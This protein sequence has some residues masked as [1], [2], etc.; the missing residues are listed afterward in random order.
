MRTFRISVEG[1]QVVIEHGGFLLAFEPRIAVGGRL[2]KPLSLRKTENGIL[3]EYEW[4][5]GFIR[6]TEWGSNTLVVEVEAE[7]LS[8]DGI[9]AE[10][11]SRLQGFEDLLLFHYTYDPDKYFGEAEEPYPYPQLREAG[12]VEISAW[13]FPIHRKDYK[14]LPKNLK[15]SQL[16]AKGG[17]TYA[18]LLPISNAGARGH[19]MSFDDDSFSIVLNRGVKGSWSKAYLFALA[20]SPSPYE[21]IESSYEASFTAVGRVNQLRK[22]KTLPEVFRV[23]GWCSWNACWRE[24]TADKVLSAYKSLLENGIKPGFVLIDDGWQDEE[25]SGW[26]GF[27]IRGLEPNPNKFPAGFACVVN[28]LK[29]MGARYVGL[30]HT[31]NV[32]WGGIAKESEFARTFADCLMEINNYIVPNPAKSFEMF[33]KWYARLKSAGLDFVKVDNQ[34]FVGY[35]YLGCMGFEEAA[36]G[37]HEGLEAAAYLNSLEVLNCMAQQPENTF[38]WIRSTVSRNCVDYIV[39]HRKSR[40]KLHLYFNAYNALFMSQV[41]WPDWDMFQ[42]HD[43]WALQQAV[44]RAVSGGPVYLTDE[45]GKTIAGIVKP[46]A[47]SDGSLPLPDHPAFP[48]EDVIMHD[49]YNEQIPLKIFTRVT[50]EGLGVYGIVA[51]FNVNRDDAPVKGEVKPS[52]ALL[53]EGRYLIYEYFS[54]ELREGRMEFELEPM[55]VKLFIIAPCSPWLTPIGLKD[56]YIAPRGIE[57]AHIF[58]DKEAVFKLRE[59]GLLVAKTAAEVKV[60]GGEILEVEPLLK[61]RCQEKIVRLSAR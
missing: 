55:G 4:G 45:P 15:V 6:F 47:F 25:G 54:E 2:A 49:P 11:K 53:P 8:E 41:V 3:A 61:L 36:R 20:V 38:N 60:E 22:N 19:I 29:S 57:C 7:G 27:R 16:L 23:L 59:G 26:P 28:R 40:N 50:V 35:A 30:W 46:L 13:S 21:A 32:H 37:L 31:L 10:L 34:M 18:Y 5:C 12:D 48:T 43:P 52:N 58:D 42:S 14:G 56:I 17:E 1:L 33:R 44:A 39:P 24:P 9:L 51:A